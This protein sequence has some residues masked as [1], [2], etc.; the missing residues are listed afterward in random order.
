MD[1][2]ETVRFIKLTLKIC[3]YFG[4]SPY[5]WSEEN[6]VE[7]SGRKS[8]RYFAFLAQ[9]VLYLCYESFVIARLIHVSFFEPNVSLGGKGE[10]QYIAYGYTLPVVLHLC[11][12]VHDDQFHCLCNRIIQY[13]KS[14]LKGK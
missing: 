14:A 9:F 13:Q 3:N 4:T 8:P 2:E 11:S 1:S 12:F 7:F 6:K 10:L 5:T